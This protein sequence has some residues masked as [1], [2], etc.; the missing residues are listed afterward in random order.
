[1]VHFCSLGT[2]QYSIM[3]LQGLANPVSICSENLGQANSLF[4]FSRYKP[5]MHSGSLGTIKQCILLIQEP[6]NNQF[7]FSRNNQ[8]MHSGSL[9][10]IKRCILV[11]QEQSNNAFWFCRKNQTMHSCYLGTIKQ[12]ILV[13]KEQSNNQFWFS[14]NKQ[15]DSYLSGAF[16]FSSVT[17]QSV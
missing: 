16:M 8:T 3:V 17:L 4:W 14:R 7:L 10:T 13:L 15:T 6:S 5:T 2:I 12:S 9:G 1:M 11:L